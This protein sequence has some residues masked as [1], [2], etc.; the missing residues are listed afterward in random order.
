MSMLK[1]LVPATVLSLVVATSAWAAPSPSTLGGL[2]ERADNNLQQVQ[3]RDRDAHRDRSHRHG[4]R[5][6]H[7]YHSAPRGWHRHGH[8][9]HDWRTRGCIIVGPVWFCP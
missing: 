7:R 3:H 8:R 9:P 5:T 4:Y 2:M 1:A 6:G